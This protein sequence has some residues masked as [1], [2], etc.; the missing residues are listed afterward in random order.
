M[1]NLSIEEIESKL[2]KSNIKISNH[3]ISLQLIGF[4]ISDLNRK[5]VEAEDALAKETRK[6]EAAQKALI[7]VKGVLSKVSRIRNRLL[8]KI[9][10]VKRRD[11][12]IAKQEELELE[13]DTLK[14]ELQELCAH[15]FIYCRSGYAGDS[16]HDYKNGH[17][18]HRYCIVC[19]LSEKGQRSTQRDYVGIHFEILTES[20][21]RIIEEERYIQSKSIDIWVPL[22]AVLHPLEKNVARALNP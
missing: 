15:T 16:A 2:K 19:E 12:T 1:L 18:E 10:Q 14:L 21:D 5:K 20:D 4:E 22:G 6:R 9:E 13:I 7:L 17:P 11:I 8:R 3:E